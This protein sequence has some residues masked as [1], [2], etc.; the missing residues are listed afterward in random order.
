MTNDLSFISFYVY[1]ISAQVFH[2]SA[3]TKTI[4]VL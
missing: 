3:S 4:Y 2:D 1:C